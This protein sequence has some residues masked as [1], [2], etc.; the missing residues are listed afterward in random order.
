M[1]LRLWGKCLRWIIQGNEF[2][3]QIRRRG[4]ALLANA[5]DM[6]VW[7][8]GGQ[9]FFLPWGGGP[10]GVVPDRPKVLY[11]RHLQTQG[12]YAVHTARK[13]FELA[14]RLWWWSWIGR[15]PPLP[16]RALTYVWLF[17]TKLYFACN[18]VTTEVGS[19]RWTL[20]YA[21]IIG[22]GGQTFIYVGTYFFCHLFRNLPRSCGLVILLRSNWSFCCLSKCYGPQAFNETWP[23]SEKH[24]T[25]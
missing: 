3:V 22:L 23:C 10:C 15:L 13:G 12:R 19:R 8:A 25:W 18:F 7:D 14:V 16:H 5:L 21:L 24:H 4:K 1:A 9:H 11:V 6:Q 20:F 2:R 17:F